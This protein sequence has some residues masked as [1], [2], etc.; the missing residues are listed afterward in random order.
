MRSKGPRQ[1]GLKLLGIMIGSR[2][3]HMTLPVILLLVI[4]NDTGRAEK[5][6]ASGFIDVTGFE[7]ITPH[8]FSEVWTVKALPGVPNRTAYLLVADQ[9][10]GTAIQAS[11]DNSFAALTRK[12]EIDPE[13]FPVLDWSWKISTIIASARL[14]EK[15]RDDAPVR[16][17]ISFGRN[18]IMGGRPKGSL[19]YVW[20]AEEPVE[21]FTKNP[22][23]QNVMTI[24]VESGVSRVGTWKSYRRNV[25][26]DYI[27]SFGEK[28]GE[29]RA[30]TL[31][32]DTDNTK[33][34]VTSW[35]GPISFHKEIREYDREALF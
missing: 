13:Q 2:L 23:A 15:N 18:L 4:L 34:H 26:K 17:I 9:D 5:T 14:V 6:D 10:R 30:I 16:I 22:H 28:P 7:T 8:S 25:I 21:T 35:Y 11:A 1:I 33:G 31:I 12:L 3:L 19:C 29:I 27:K 24:V 32:S 20:S